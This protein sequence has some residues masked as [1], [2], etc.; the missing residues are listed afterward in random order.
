[1]TIVPELGNV[2]FDSRMVEN[3]LSKLDVNKATGPDDISP[4]VLKQCAHV[5]AP[6]L[7]LLFN[8]SIVYW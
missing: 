7:A 2:K 3:A 5:L 6:S 8:M 1:M 4:V